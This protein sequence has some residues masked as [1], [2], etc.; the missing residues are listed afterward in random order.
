MLD[1]WK[2]TEAPVTI[3]LLK[4]MYLVQA[5]EIREGIEFRTAILSLLS[6]PKGVLAVNVL[7]R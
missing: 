5:L 4:R 6:A 7:E 1:V 2:R 3:R